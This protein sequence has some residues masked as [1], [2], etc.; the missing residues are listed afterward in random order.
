[1]NISKVGLTPYM[2]TD[3]E[4]DL[5]ILAHFRIGKNLKLC[6]NTYLAVMVFCL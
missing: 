6:T 5:K 4:T 1:M 2:R 3:P